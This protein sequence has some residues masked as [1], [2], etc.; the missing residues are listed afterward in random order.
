MLEEH[1]DD[2][3]VSLGTS[4]S[5]WPPICSN[6]SAILRY[7]V[8]ILTKDSGVCASVQDAYDSVRHDLKH[9]F[10]TIISIIF[11]VYHLL[12]YHTVLLYGC[13]RV[14]L[15]YYCCPFRSALKSILLRRL[16]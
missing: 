16:P 9:Y 14:V 5:L 3:A 10:S 13:T 12:Y 15:K 6:T 2:G 1:I 4:S 11:T 8:V 7:S